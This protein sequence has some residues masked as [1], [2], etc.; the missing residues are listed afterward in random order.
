MGASEAK[1]AA[2]TAIQ[3]DA[4]AGPDGAEVTLSSEAGDFEVTVPPAGRWRTRANKALRQGDFDEWA[5]LVLSSAD[6]GS[7]CDADP[8]ND[9]VE[10]FFQAWKEAA[11]EDLGKSRAS[12]RGSSLTRRR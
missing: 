5:E 12:R 1:P 11:G 7:W 10:A 6:Y 2:L 3:A 8:T 4:D 9:D